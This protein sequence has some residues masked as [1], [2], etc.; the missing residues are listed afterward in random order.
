VENV[1]WTLLVVMSWAICILCHT[2]CEVP[3]SRKSAL[4]YVKSWRNLR[5]TM[6][7]EKIVSRIGA[8]SICYHLVQNVTCTHLWNWH[9]CHFVWVWNLAS[10]VTR[11]QMEGLWEEG[12]EENICCRRE[13]GIKG[14]RRFC[15]ELHVCYPSPD[16]IN[17]I[18]GRKIIHTWHVAC[19]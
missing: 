16:I 1:F 4:R 3:L 13:V 7:F 12:G 6:I 19:I 11:A 10:Y 15:S 14:C 17:V 5:R 2:A 9:S 8:G 18:I